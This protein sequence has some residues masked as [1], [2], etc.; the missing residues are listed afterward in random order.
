M[1]ERAIKSIFNKVTDDLIYFIHV[2]LFE[3]D[4]FVSF[5]SLKIV[6]IGTTNQPRE[7]TVLAPDQK[8]CSWPNS[9]ASKLYWHT[10]NDWIRR[11]DSSGSHQ[12]HVVKK[13][14]VK[15]RSSMRQVGAGAACLSLWST[16]QALAAKSSGRSYDEEQ[17]GIVD[18]PL[19][20]RWQMSIG[21][22]SSG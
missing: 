11:K 6:A 10:N 9:P 3:P 8:F 1:L 14:K 2:K 13:S 19:S 5:V 18:S 22:Q 12:K 4:Y 21:G 15:Q 7:K 16:I 20:R 17:G